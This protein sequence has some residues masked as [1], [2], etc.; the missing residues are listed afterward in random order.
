MQ[1]LEVNKVKKIVNFP[2][3]AVLTSHFVSFW[4]TVQFLLS[5]IAFVII[6]KDEIHAPYIHKWRLKGI[7]VISNSVNKS[8]ERLY[9]EKHLR[10][11]CMADTMDEIGI[12]KLLEDN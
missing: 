1:F 12:E 11:S 8:L 5:G 3:H 4:S 6:D 10:I 2:L 7:R 9:F